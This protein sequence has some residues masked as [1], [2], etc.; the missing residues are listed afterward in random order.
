MKKD[1]LILSGAVLIAGILVAQKTGLLGRVTSGRLTP[2]D[3]ITGFVPRT[4][5]LDTTN[6][7]RGYNPADP[8]AYVST[9]ELI[10]GATDN[11]WMY[12]PT[13]DQTID[14]ALG[15]P[16]GPRV[17]TPLWMVTR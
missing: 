1:T 2:V 4:S 16:Q 17:N 3:L 11:D 14:A 13:F 5:P 9:D 15:A 8:G 10:A 12:I 7:E 6:T